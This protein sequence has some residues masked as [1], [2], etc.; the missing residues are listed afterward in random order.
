M[1]RLII[2][3]LI[4]SVALLGFFGC[5]TPPKAQGG[6]PDFVTNPPSAEDAIYG[7]GYGKSSNQAKAIEFAKA[8]ARNDVARQISV[9]IDGALTDYFQEA[10]ADD[11]TQTITFI[12]SI[13]RE[14]VSQK[15]NG[16]KAIKTVPMDDDSVWVLVE[17]SLVS[18]KDDFAE[19]VEKFTRNEDAAFA[20][21]KAEEALKFLDA[22]LANEPTTSEP[23]EK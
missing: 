4:A 19:T 18:F 3:S 13:S 22:K 15:L 6:L 9:Q 1:K 11:N 12:E 23:V 14:I 16:A 17:Y 8:R 7:V 21:F 10:G 2:V 5:A 20:E